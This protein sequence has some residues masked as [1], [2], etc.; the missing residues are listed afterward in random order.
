MKQ[1]YLEW[2]MHMNV[3]AKS[4]QRGEVVTTCALGIYLTEPANKFR[5]FAFK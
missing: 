5:W 4:I 3:G 2:R 1:R